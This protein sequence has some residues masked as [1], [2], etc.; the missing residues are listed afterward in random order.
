[1]EQGEKTKLLSAVNL[2]DSLTRQEVDKLGSRMPEMH[3]ER[4][5]ILY[6]PT[7]QSR[8][9]FLLLRGRMRIY[10]VAEDREI[11][12][13]V[14]GAGDMFGE[15]ALAD[16]RS[17]RAYAQAT[18]PSEVVLMSHDILYGLVRDKPEV[19]LRAVELLSER[20]SFQEDRMAD[21]GLKEVPARLAGLILQLVHSEGLVTAEG[22]KIPTRYTH[23]QLG[24]MICSK[25]VAVTRAF[26]KLQ[27]SGALELRQRYIYVKDAGALKLIA[28]GEQRG[29][30]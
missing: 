8:I 29:R 21:I 3:L 24:M 14:M 26:T 4:G 30:R 18:E 22:Y 23:E 6:T 19:G 11:T 15:A 1:L 20:L 17:Q 7:H 9:L 16:Q 25:R 13:S 28:K 5:Q 27:E 10:K 12:L 2:L